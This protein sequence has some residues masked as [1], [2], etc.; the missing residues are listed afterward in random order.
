[1]KSL[2]ETVSSIN[3]S[4]TL[5][6]NRLAL[7]LQREGKK[8]I[9]LTAGEPDFDTPEP[10]IAS[11]LKAMKSGKTRYTP[12]AGIPELREAIAFKFS[13]E[14]GKH[15]TPSQVVVTNGGKH[16]LH[17]ALMSI[18]NAGDEVII[19]TPAWVSYE[20]QV[21]LAGGI[22]VFVE[23][24]DSFI[25]DIERLKNKITERTKAIIINS[26]NNP[27]GA[28]Y[29][30]H[31][32]KEVAELAIKHDLY[33]ISD[34]VYRHLIYVGRHS[35]I[36]SVE[37][38]A[39]RTILIDSLSKSHAMTGWRI[40]FAI[41]PENVALSMVKLISHTTSNV[42]TPTQWAAIDA[43][44]FDTSYM[45]EEFSRRREYV[46]ERLD[47]L[48]LPHSTPDG[49]FYVLLDVSAVAEDDTVWVEELLM[50]EHV[51]TV[52]GT[53]FY[54]PGTVR[55]S[56]AASMEDIKEAFDRIERFIS[57]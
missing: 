6:Y 52:P 37:G 16:A 28:V 27:T 9:R 22:P 8:V 18:I 13:E 34:E 1:M 10:I 25:P 29:P 39:D 56:F 57:G 3:E 50:K 42:N 17:L 20:P 36:I 26:P 23:T 41:A 30:F 21:R 53:A 51:A 45:K 12:A 49:A 35:S 11:A 24:D 55:I 40:G 14:Y 48:G 5:K 47:R 4:I 31:I 38:M 46:V 19:F 54:A 7:Q 44:S 43:L 15:W 32:L 2:S 33:V